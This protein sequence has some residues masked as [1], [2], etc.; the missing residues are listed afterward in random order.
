[1]RKLDLILFLAVALEVLPGCSDP[2]SIKNPYQ[3]WKAY[4]LQDYSFV[5]QL[6]CYCHPVYGRRFRVYV[7]SGR[8]VD[9]V[10]L[11]SQESFPDA[12]RQRFFRT[13]DELFSLV[14]NSSA[15]KVLALKVEYDSTYG[16]PSYLF[17]DQ[18]EGIDDEMTWIT[19]DLKQ[20]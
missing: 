20:E 17:I 11:E 13:A 16:Y 2:A 4:H 15:S 7:K 5:Q 1:M 14:W 6:E 8:I 18:D 9:V 19:S 3:R 10:D 12:Q